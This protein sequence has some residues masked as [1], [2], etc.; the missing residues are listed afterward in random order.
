MTNSSYAR[1][2]SDDGF[3]VFLFHGV[4]REHRHAVR[5]YTRKH[6]ALERFVE[7]IRELRSN[8]VAVS[9]DDV[10][11][12]NGERKEL[13]PRTF[14]ITFDDGFENNHSVAAPALDDLR[15]PATFYVT[16]RFIDENAGSW[17]DLIE[18][19]VESRQQVEVNLPCAQGRF[20]TRDEKIGLLDAIRGFVKGDPRIDP[21]SFAEEV[22]KQLG[23]GTLPLDVDLDDKM[24]WKQVR[25]LASHPLFSVGGHGHTHRILSFLAANELETEIATSLE[26]LRDHQID[27]R[28]YSYP[29]GLAHCYSASVIDVLRRHGIVCSPTAEHGTNRIGDD[30][31]HLKRIMVST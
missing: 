26:L 8:G 19:A 29:E 21:Y 17:I 13:P 11:R 12:A 18:R 25:A 6:L 16:T 22:T 9:L 5:N 15:V 2:L 14:V 1:F 20:A 31:F 30:L 4:V 24:S 28:H 7:V 23:V 3:A 27:T 10:V